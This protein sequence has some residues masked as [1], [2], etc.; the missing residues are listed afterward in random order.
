MSLGTRLGWEGDGWTSQQPSRVCA[1]LH[2]SC[3]TCTFPMFARFPYVATRPFLSALAALLPCAG[4]DASPAKGGASSSCARTV[5]ALDGDADVL[6]EV[7]ALLGTPGGPE[8][9]RCTFR[10]GGSRSHAGS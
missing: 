3:M 6:S 7:A 8:S 1:S 10:W 9:V 2:V 5:A 4:E